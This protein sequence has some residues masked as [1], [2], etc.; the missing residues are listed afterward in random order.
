MADF[1]ATMAGTT[2][3]SIAAQVKA[4]APMQGDMDQEHKEFVQTISKLLESGAIDVTRP[5]S[6]LNKDVYEKLDAEWKSKTDLTMMNVASLLCHIYEF[7]KSKQTP[8]A[9]P[10]LASMIEELWQMKK[11]IEVHADVFKF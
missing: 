5:E 8:D 4:G 1:A 9:C 3:L 10:Q 11:R 6:F 7:Y 2:D